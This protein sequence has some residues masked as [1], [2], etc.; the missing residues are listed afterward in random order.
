MNKARE[1]TQ[2]P[3]GDF[4]FSVFLGRYRHEGALV[5]P[6]FVWTVSGVALR[7]SGIGMVTSQQV[8][9]W[10]LEELTRDGV[11]YQE[12]TVSLIAQKFGYE[13]TYDNEN[14]GL[15]IR[16]DVLAVFRKLTEGSVVWDAENRL[17]R[18]REQTD[19]PGP[20]Q[21]Y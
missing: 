7:R 1:A 16:R 8:A 17:W 14:G 15:A 4:L 10:M 5:A 3:R 18:K 21:G 13:F 11:L 12:T 6:Y 19:R 9:E 20:Q 2:Y